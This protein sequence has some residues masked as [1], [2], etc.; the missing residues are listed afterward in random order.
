MFTLQVDNDLLQKGA[1]LVGAT[2]KQ[3]EAATTSTL[4]KV[5]KRIET[6]IKRR[7]AKELRMPQRAIGDR[8]FSNTI[9]PGDSVLKVWIGTWAISPYS[10][11]SPAQTL[12][13]VR[14]GRRSFP[15]AFL[16]KIYTG[17]EKVWIRLHSP[18]YTPDLYPTKYRP[19]DRGLTGLRGRFPVVRA[20]VPIDGVVSEVVELEGDA[21]ME[22]FEKVYLQE[23]NYQV[24]VKGNA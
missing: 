1:A 15:G 14:V 3:L 18:H 4:S 17:T 12:R 20:A 19:G 9:S 13:G 10:I 5:K 24:N 7:A 8:F 22:D 11:G 23:L 21:I 2:E 16:A 6:R